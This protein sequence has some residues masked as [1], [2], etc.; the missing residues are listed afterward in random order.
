MMPILLI[1]GGFWLV[2]EWL[3][4]RVGLGVQDVPWVAR[5]ARKSSWPDANAGWMFG[6]PPSVPA[7]LMLYLDTGMEKS[8]QKICVVGLGVRW[9]SL[10]FRVPLGLGRFSY[11]TISSRDLMSVF[12]SPLR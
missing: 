5:E 2:G 4:E 6:K 10:E 8:A 12:S 7:L 3:I 11:C 9:T 1:D